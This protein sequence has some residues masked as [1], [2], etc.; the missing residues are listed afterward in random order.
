LTRLEKQDTWH[1]WKP[2]SGRYKG[3]TVYVSI[4]TSPQEDRYNKYGDVRQ[5]ILAFYSSK[6]GRLTMHKGQITQ[7]QFENNTSLFTIQY[8][9]DQLEEVYKGYKPRWEEG[10]LIRDAKRLLLN[11]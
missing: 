2:K 11:E 6:T 10:R 8:M 7:Y 4:I 9:I 1:I 5:A 3:R